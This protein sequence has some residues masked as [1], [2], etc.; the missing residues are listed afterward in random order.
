[1][2]LP[3]KKALNRLFLFIIRVCSTKK[4]FVCIAGNIGSGKTTVASIIESIF[5]F[6]KYEEVVENN[7]Y[8]PLFYND[9]KKWSYKIQRY[10][11]MTRFV[12]HENIAMASE[13]GV[14][15]RS[16]YEDMEIFAQ[17]QIRLGNFTPEQ[18]RRYNSFCKL[19]YEEIRPPD[20]L[21]YLR[22]SIPVLKERISRRGRDYEA[23]LARTDNNYLAELQKLYDRW[24]ARYDLGPK[25]IIDTD[26]L[27]FVDNP[28]HVKIL[29]NQIKSA[30]MRKE[31]KLTKFAK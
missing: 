6:K 1:M 5:G 28:D 24:I 12:A 29:V 16:I 30:L 26:T 13:S 18:A 19:L 4:Y 22:T 17:L 21:I 9:M 20:L 25:L 23:E 10:F 11:L 7:P 14:Q 31:K 2:L 3:L 8:L 27:N 15:D